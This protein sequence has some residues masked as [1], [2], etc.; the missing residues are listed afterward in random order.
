MVVERR[1]TEKRAQEGTQFGIVEITTEGEIKRGRLG[2]IVRYPGRKLGITICRSL[3]YAPRRDFSSFA[4]Y[5]SSRAMA[6]RFSLM[7]K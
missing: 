1:L 6:S 3:D 7:V 5:S 4:R 2:G